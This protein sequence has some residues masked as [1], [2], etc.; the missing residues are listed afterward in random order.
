MLFVKCS[1]RGEQLGVVLGMLFLIAVCFGI[2]KFL[3]GL[4]EAGAETMQQAADMDLRVHRRGGAA[5]ATLF[6][7]AGLAIC[8]ISGVVFALV[9]LINAVRFLTGTGLVD[10]NESW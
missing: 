7:Y 5:R 1:S 9:G 4:S 6:A 10:A 2:G 8:G 3:L